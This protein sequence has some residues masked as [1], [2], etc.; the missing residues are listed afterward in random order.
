MEDRGPME[1]HYKALILCIDEKAL[2]QVEGGKLKINIV[3]SRVAIEHI[4]TNKP[5]VETKTE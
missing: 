1:V 2:F 5:I 4:N 3:N